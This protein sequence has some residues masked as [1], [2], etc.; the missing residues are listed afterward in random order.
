M[1]V[2]SRHE[3]VLPPT[4]DKLACEVIWIILCAGHSA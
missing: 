1:L 3:L 2:W 4:P